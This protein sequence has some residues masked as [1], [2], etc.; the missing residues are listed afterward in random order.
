MCG[1]GC[2]QQVVVQRGVVE[3]IL[4]CAK[5]NG[6]CGSGTDG[7]GRGTRMNRNKKSDSNASDVIGVAEEDR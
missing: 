1:E 3:G 4:V 6:Y 2:A 5:G 7:N